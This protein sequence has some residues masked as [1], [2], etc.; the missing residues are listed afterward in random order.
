MPMRIPVTMLAEY[1]GQAPASQFTARDTGEVVDL[2]PMLKFEVEQPDGDV[3]LIPLRENQL[4][5]A[6][7]F[8]HGKLA[9][10]DLVQ[11]VGVVVLQDRGSDRDSYL[12]VE[13]A[14][15][16]SANGKPAAAAA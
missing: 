11:L 12:R 10:G 3:G 13:H 2:R 6:A 9:K 8:D 14:T 5:E 16:V 15:R 4:D 7:D 1:R